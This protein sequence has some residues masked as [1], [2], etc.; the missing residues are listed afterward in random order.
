MSRYATRRIRLAA[1][2]ALLVGAASAQAGVVAGMRAPDGLGFD[3]D[4]KPHTLAE[5]RGKVVVLS[6]WASWCGYCLKELPVLEKIQRTLGKDRIEVVAINVD[7]ERAKYV[8]MRR[9]L[10][11]FQFT[12]TVDDD[13]ALAD[14]YG[15]DG[16]PHLVLVDKDGR[17]AYVHIGYAE[18]QLPFF[19]EEINELLDEKQGS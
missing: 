7:K 19:V 8:A 10:K 14:A 17:A 18:R 4:G 15:V 6:F 5:H 13:H 9:K 11:D 3:R 1:M 16:L 12:M 2:L